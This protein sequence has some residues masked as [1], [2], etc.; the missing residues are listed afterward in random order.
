MGYPSSWDRILVAT[1]PGLFESIPPSW[2]TLL[3]PLLTEINAIDH[4][5]RKEEEAGF[6]I[7]PRRDRIFAALELHPDQVRVVI[8]GQDPYPDLGYAVGR[9]FAVAEETHPLPGSLRN[10]FAERRS[11]VGGEDPSPSLLS[12]QEQ[13]VLL[14]NRTLTTR[15]GESNAHSSIGW[16]RITSH[17]VSH[18]ANKGAVGLL[19]GKSAQSTQPLFGDRAVTGT[20]PSPLS[21]HRGFFGSRPFSKVNALLGDEIEW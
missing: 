15:A 19:W 10:I 1:S 13:G 21:A 20:H 3:R 14:L 7:S 18:S 16:E 8:V 11:D 12:W 5:L 2:R 6:L 4:Y 9:A 17:I